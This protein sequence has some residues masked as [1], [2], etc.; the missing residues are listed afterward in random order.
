LA[1]EIGHD[2]HRVR[3][4]RVASMG[5]PLV[6]GGN[7][8]WFATALGPPLLLQ[9][10]RRLLAAEIGRSVT[11]TTRFSRRFNGAAAC[12]RR[13]SLAQKT[14]KDEAARLQWGRR[15][16]AAEIVHWAKGKTD[17]M[18]ASMGPPLVGGGNRMTLIFAS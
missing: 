7:W 12:W 13:K 18:I 2:A 17:D 9:W 11:V 1:A 5:P 14:I 10:G 6:G 16:L 4:V 3:V 15:L 8:S